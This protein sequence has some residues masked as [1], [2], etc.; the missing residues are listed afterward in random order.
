MSE[1]EIPLIVFTCGRK[2]D[3]EH[4]WDGPEEPLYREDGSV[5]GGTA[6]CSICGRSAFEEA[7]W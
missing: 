6:T 5:C 7:E 1:P 2:P 4:K 3:H